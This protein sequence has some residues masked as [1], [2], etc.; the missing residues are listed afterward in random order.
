MEFLDSLSDVTELQGSIKEIKKSL[1]EVNAGVISVEN[2]FFAKAQKSFELKTS[3]VEV[4]KS[5][6]DYKSTKVTI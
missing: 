2:D 4:S 5:L 1:D 6:V 3:Y